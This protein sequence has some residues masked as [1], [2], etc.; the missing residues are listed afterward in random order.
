MSI[1][2]RDI[3]GL[4]DGVTVRPPHRPVCCWLLFM[5]RSS[6]WIRRRCSSIRH[7]FFRRIFGLFV[8]TVFFSVRKPFLRT[9]CK[10]W[11]SG[12]VRFMCA[13]FSCPYID[14]LFLLGCY[15]NAVL[16][17]CINVLRSLSFER[18]ISR[19]FS[20]HSPAINTVM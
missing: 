14:L 18:I 1:W 7:R 2:S 4:P 5:F 17:I 10:S 12:Y 3:C 16:Y 19:G 13:H 8:S 6:D 15:W 9:R 11:R 20:H